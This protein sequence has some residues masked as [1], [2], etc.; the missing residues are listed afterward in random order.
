M[1]CHNTQCDRV[2]RHQPTG[3]AAAQTLI[4]QLTNL[5]YE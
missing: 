4:Q 1:P 5:N 2:F 3:L